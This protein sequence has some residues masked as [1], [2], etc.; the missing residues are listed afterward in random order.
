MNEQFLDMNHLVNNSLLFFIPSFILIILATVVI[1]RSYHLKDAILAAF[2]MYAFAGANLFE[3]IRHLVAAEY[4]AML[5]IGVVIPLLLTG[6]AF[7]THLQYVH[8]SYFSGNYN[9]TTS[10]SFYVVLSLLLV[11]VIILSQQGAFTYERQFGWYYVNEASIKTLVYTGF[12]IYVALLSYFVIKSYLNATPRF[13]KFVFYNALGFFGAIIGFVLILVLFK[14]DLPPEPLVTLVA[15]V[16]GGLIGISVLFFNFSP[17]FAKRYQLLMDISPNAVL[18]MT[19]DLKI[20]E[21]NKNAAQLLGIQSDVSIQPLFHHPENQKQLQEFLQIIVKQKE[22]EFYRFPFHMADYS[23]N[24]YAIEGAYFEL[25]HQQLMYILIRDITKEYE[26]QQYMA[27]LAYR[28]GLTKLP[29][30]QYFLEKFEEL[31]TEGRPGVLVL[32]DLNFFKQINDVHGHAVGDEVL[33]HTAYLLNQSI[34]E[35]V[36][37]ARLGGDE[38]ILFF[39][40]TT[41]VAFLSQLQKLRDVFQKT[42]YVQDDLSIQVVP[43]FGYSVIQAD[44]TLTF[45]KVYQE[46]D[47]SMYRDKKRVK[48][49]YS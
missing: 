13:K 19:M 40:N 5:H 3:G 32:S 10:K 4:N 33:K 21:A 30:R 14:N 28:D 37:C 35:G 26:Q 44:A 41:E 17:S 45:E 9:V 34:P 8:T 2:C 47:A 23:L 25:N 24:Y 6:L 43:S 31:M 39:P 49:S 38:F 12:A 46:A 42:P 15:P 27:F 18:L 7:A 1:T 16:A 11:S 36:L 22:V 29:N 48:A 20:L